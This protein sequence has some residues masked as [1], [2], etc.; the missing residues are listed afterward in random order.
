MF[1]RN[2]DDVTIVDFEKEV[3]RR[4]RKQ[5]IQKRWNEFTGFVRDNKDVLVLVVPSAV[6]VVSGVTKIT[7]KAI[8]AHTLNKEIRFKECTIY[9]RSLGRYVQLRKPL[10]AAQALTIEER[11]ANGEKL[12]LILEDMRLLKK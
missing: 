1:K 11:R 12:H 7:S 9:D 2:N 4:E 6:A 5:A 10:T 3:K 8:A